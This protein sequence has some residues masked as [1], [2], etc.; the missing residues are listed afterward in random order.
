MYLYSCVFLLSNDEVG[1]RICTL[2]YLYS[3]VMQFDCVFVLLDDAVEMCICPL[4]YVYSQMMRLECLIYFLIIQSSSG[5]LTPSKLNEEQQQ[6]ILDAHN[7]LRR[8][9]GA[10]DME[11]LVGIVS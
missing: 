7:E 8:H 2:A 6:T 1:L 11:L 10:A 5:L 3:Q 9:Q 4:A